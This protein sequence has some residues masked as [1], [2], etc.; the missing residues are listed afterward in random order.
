MKSRFR[1]AILGALI[2]S[3]AMAHAEIVIVNGAT[4]TRTMV[5]SDGTFGGCMALLSMP[6]GTG[7]ATNWVSFSCSGVFTDK[8]R[9]YRMLDQAQM[10]YVTGKKVTV[11]AD[12]TKLHNTYCFAQRVTVH[13]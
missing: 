6:I 12:N 3:S 13:D 7:C 10:A 2:G 8:D 11:Y 4:V 9:A 5:L 1:I